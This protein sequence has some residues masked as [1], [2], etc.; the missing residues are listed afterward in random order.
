MTL[1]N[2]LI[3]GAAKSG[4]TSLYYY[5]KQHPDIY[6][7]S[8]K[9]PHFFANAEVVG[10][11]TIMTLN[12]YKKLFCKVATEK[13]IG[14]ASTGYL[15]F[16]ESARLIKEQIPEC[17]II[18][19]LRNPVE[20]AY[21][22]YCHEVREG[23]EKMKF[24]DAINEE[25][26]DGRRKDFGKDI[27]FNYVQLGYMYENVMRYIELFDRENIFIGFYDDLKSDTR[28]IMS[29][30]FSFLTVD[31][32]FFGKWTTVHNPSGKPRLEWFHKML[33]SRNIIRRAIVYP[34]RFF[35]P[36]EVRH[37]VWKN[38]KDWNVNVGQKKYMTDEEKK[39]LLSL[40]K[41]EISNI[42]LLTG[43]DLSHWRSM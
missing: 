32:S 14:E 21:S 29:E 20:R 16:S 18:I 19:M 26:V 15:H 35:L 28:K 2:F 17:K 37:K 27:S 24:L 33:I 23:L 3:I 31:N 22:M 12:D 39:F 7:P 30:I 34:A 41:K 5:L 1:P 13:A 25:L 4:T 36:K 42:E 9:E 6:M 8:Y 10:I 43:R 11:P 38:I 40:Y